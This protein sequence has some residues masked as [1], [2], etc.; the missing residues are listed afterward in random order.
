MKK[1]L[2]FTLKKLFSFSKYLSVCLDFLVMQKNGLIRKTWLIS[3]SIT[4]QLGSQT[5][6]MHILINISRTKGN[7][8]IKLK[9]YFS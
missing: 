8:A 5:I 7:Q 1:A 9:K 4:S 3:N 6:A 2:Y